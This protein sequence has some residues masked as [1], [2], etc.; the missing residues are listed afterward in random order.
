MLLRLAMV[1]V[2]AM[3]ITLAIAMEILRDQTARNVKKITS[4]LIA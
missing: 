3:M 2:H 1:K 4:E